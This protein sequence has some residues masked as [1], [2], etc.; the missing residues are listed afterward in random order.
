[1]LGIGGG[2]L[3]PVMG[4]AAHNTYVS[5]ATETGF[6]GF[7]LFLSILAMAA[8][9]SVRAGG[10]NS[11]LWIAVLMIWAIGVLSLSWEFRK[12]TWLFLGFVVIAGSLGTEVRAEPAASPALVERRLP[13]AFPKSTARP[14]AA[15]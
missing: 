7:V 3:D 2:A 13:V 6:T 4:T 12:L 8:Y 1:M 5:V 14:K 15:R 9:Q 11:A 10:K